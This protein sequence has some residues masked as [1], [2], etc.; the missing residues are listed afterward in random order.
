MSFM[1]L[2]QML[3]TENPK[4]SL[5]VTMDI[6]SLCTNISDEQAIISLFK[7]FKKHPLKIIFLY[8]L[9]YLLKNNAFQFDGFTFTQTCGMAMG[10]KLAPDLAIMY[11]GNLE[12]EF[13]D[14]Q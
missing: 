3:N 1:D 8:V 2:V 9:K 13:L 6:E 5:L 10:T 12:E 11:I 7:K 14:N 4:H